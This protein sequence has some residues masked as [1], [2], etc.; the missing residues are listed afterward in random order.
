MNQ[1][2]LETYRMLSMSGPQGKKSEAIR[3]LCDE[4][5]HL[6]KRN[7][8]RNGFVPPTMD[9]IKAYA[10]QI[11]VL[12]LEDC[13]SFRDHHQARGWKLGR[14][15]MIDWQAAFRTWMRNRIK[16]SPSNG[17]IETKSIGQRYGVA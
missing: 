6:Q 8:K 14:G 3:V 10:R 9:E 4:I 5:D 17:N 7:G 16:Y 1:D 13:E 11:H 12:T 2:V 15:P